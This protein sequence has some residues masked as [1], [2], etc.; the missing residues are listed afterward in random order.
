MSAPEGPQELS[1]AI[2]SVM[3]GERL[4]VSAEA[5]C[6]WLAWYAEGYEQLH[7]L[8]CESEDPGLREACAGAWHAA[9]TALDH[10]TAESLGAATEHDQGSLT[11]T[12]RPAP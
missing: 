10:I 3:L 12:S 5:V 2:P 6:E 11:D 8:A 7:E 1:P 9:R 4:Y